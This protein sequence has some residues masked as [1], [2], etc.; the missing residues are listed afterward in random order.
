MEDFTNEELA[1]IHL[2]YPSSE[3]P[4]IALKGSFTTAVVRV[5]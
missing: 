3:W 5:T 1:N 2:M 4:C